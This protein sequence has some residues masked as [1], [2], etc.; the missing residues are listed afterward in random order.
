M[1]ANASVIG[2]GE[3]FRMND[4]SLG[5]LSSVDLRECWEDEAKD[6]TPWLTQDHNLFLLGKTLGIELELEAQ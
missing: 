1:P 3:V 6:F 4:Q 2:C 5:R